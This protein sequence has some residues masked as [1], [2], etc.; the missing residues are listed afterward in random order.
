MSMKERLI[1][2]IEEL[3]TNIQVDTDIKEYLK[4]R[5]REIENLEKSCQRPNVN[6]LLNEE[7][8]MP[9]MRI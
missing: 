9:D 4:T 6:Q 5:L 2:Q 3:E 7:K 1:K 8:L